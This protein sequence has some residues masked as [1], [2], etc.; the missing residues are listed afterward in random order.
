[1][2]LHYVRFAGFGVRFAPH[3]P[4][5]IELAPPAGT[6]KGPSLAVSIE[7][8]DLPDEVEIMA[9]PPFG[10]REQLDVCGE[11]SPGPTADCWSVEVGGVYVIDWPEGFAAVSSPVPTEPPFVMFAGGSGSFVYAQGPLD[12]SDTPSLDEMKAEGQSEVTRGALGERGD[13]EFIEFSY[14]HANESWRQRHVKAM[15][16]PGIT[17]I[18]SSQSLEADRERT[19]AASLRVAQSL[20]PYV[21]TLN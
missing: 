18:I 3:T 14:L 16:A 17:V 5:R 6:A 7:G 20:R 13:L 21:V 1:M 12:A 11:L 15:F 10:D 9:A 2:S 19:N 8:E 4:F